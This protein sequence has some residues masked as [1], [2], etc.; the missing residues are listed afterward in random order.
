[1]NKLQR[2]LLTSYKTPWRWPTSQA[3]TCR[4]IN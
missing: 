1:M 3:E 4:R 2:T